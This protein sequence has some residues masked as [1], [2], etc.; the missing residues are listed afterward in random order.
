MTR[1]SR[2]YLLSMFGAVVVWMSALALTFAAPGQAFAQAAAGSITIASGQVQ[3]QRG[4]TTLPAGAGTPVNVGDRVLTGLNGHAV[5]VL[6]DQSRLE[7]GPASAINLDQLT[8]AG[9]PANV[10]AGPENFLMTSKS[11]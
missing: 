1:S 5:I 11:G 3:V 8:G 2:N 7:L 10:V 6:N 4:A 9:A